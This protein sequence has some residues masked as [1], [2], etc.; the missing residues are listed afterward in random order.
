MLLG[1]EQTIRI[2]FLIENHT[3]NEEATG[4]IF[5]HILFRAEQTVL[6]GFLFDNHIENEELRGERFSD[7]LF[8]AEQTVLI[9]FLIHNHVAIEEVRAGIFQIYCCV[10]SK[11]FAFIFRLT[12]ALELNKSEEQ[13]FHKYCSVH[14]K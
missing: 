10:Q 14:I 5:S 3:R 1:A 4:H 6:I 11:Q 13:F 9:G 7:I 8:S 2:G 12:M